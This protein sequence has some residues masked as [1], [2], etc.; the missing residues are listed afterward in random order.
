MPEADDITQ[1]LRFLAEHRRRL[2]TLLQQQARFGLAHCPAYIVSDITE[3]RANIRRIK[4]TLRVWGE[5]I[6]DHPD[7]EEPKTSLADTNGSIPLHHFSPSQLGSSP[8]L[9]QLIVGRE[10]DLSKLKDRL[11]I[12]I[13]KGMSASAHVLTA[14]RGWPGVGKTTLAAALAHDPDIKH[15]FPDGVLWASLGTNPNVFGELAAWGRALGAF[16][17]TARTVEEASAQLSALLRNQRRLLIIDD[18]W[19][20]KQAIPFR[21]GGSECSLLITTRLPEV[22][23]SIAPTATDVYVLGVLTVEKALELLQMLAPDVVDKSLEVSRELV[24]DLEG[25]PLAIQVAGRLLN[26]EASYGFNVT[27]LLDDIREGARLIQAQAPV[28]RTEVARDTLP[29]VAALLQ[30]STDR[31]DN[32]MRDCFA[33]LG[34]FAPKP[35]TFDVEDLKSVWRVGDPKSTIYKLLDHG[36]LEPVDAGRYWMHAL[37]VAHAR[38]L[39][40]E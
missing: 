14:V 13:G 3:A 30:K 39:L 23:H 37:L 34:V 36:L 15:V 27:E 19:D 1:Q 20:A 38:S 32:Y 2:E 25:L 6:E 12:S 31:L 35:A 18:V 7:D 40:T 33:F 21:V 5:N 28:D 11:G 26:I 4:E 8:P 24:K 9:P 10:D 22:A 17:F 16:D 29:T